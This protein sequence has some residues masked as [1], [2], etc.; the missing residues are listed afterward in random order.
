MLS[1][2][3]RAHPNILMI[4]LDQPIHDVL[5]DK[6]QQQGYEVDHVVGAAEASTMLRRHGHAVAILRLPDNG[7]GGI[8]FI[9]NA[10]RRTDATPI[11]V[12]VH[13]ART[14]IAVKAMSA[15]AYDCVTL[16][17]DWEMLIAVTARAAEKS[18]L[19][20]EN[21]QLMESIKAHSEGLTNVTRKLKR[22]A[23][24]DETTQLRNQ[25]HF[26]EALAMEISRC[27]R[28]QRTFSILLIRIDQFEI[29]RTRHGV[30][31]SDLLLY[32][33]AML[34]RETMRVSDTV[35]RYDDHEFAL[36]LPETDHTGTIELCGRLDAAVNVYPFPGKESFPEKRVAVSIGAAAFPEHGTTGGALIEQGIATLRRW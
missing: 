29:Y 13:G 6:L 21:R 1:K 16:P 32:S 7:A 14:E 8:D 33:F 19:T 2:A 30:K 12:L 10:S 25:K 23:T 11:V 26:H 34:L 22:L 31:A 3:M 18:R 28:Y 27:Q 5:A 4:D 17:I 35:A 20:L 9:K 15:G 36:L 24:I